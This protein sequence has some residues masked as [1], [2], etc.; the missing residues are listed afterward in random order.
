MSDFQT[1]LDVRLSPTDTASACRAAASAL[2]WAAEDEPIAAPSVT[3]IVVTQPRERL[4]FLG[5]PSVRR[6]RLE[7]DISSASATGAPHLTHISIRGS[8]FGVGPIV[9]GRITNETMRFVTALQVE[10]D[11]GAKQREQSSTSL[12][13]DLAQ[14]AALRDRGML[15]D[16]EYA[17]AKSHALGTADPMSPAETASEQT[18][19]VTGPEV[20]ETLETSG[21]RGTGNAMAGFS[22]EITGGVAAWE[23]QGARHTGRTASSPSGASHGKSP[24]PR[25]LALAFAAIVIVV[26]A[27]VTSYQNTHLSDA[28]YSWCMAH[29]AAVSLFKPGGLEPNPNYTSDCRRAYQADATAPDPAAGPSDGGQAT[30]AAGMTPQI[31]A[32]AGLV[33]GGSQM[34]T[35]SGS[36]F[37]THEPYVGD[38]EYIELSDLTNGWNAG[39]H[40]PGDPGQDLITL[41]VVSWTDTSIAFDI[42]GGPVPW[43][44][45]TGDQVRIR[46]W[47]PS[48]SQGPAVYFSAVGP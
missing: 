28:E 13:S 1:E 16:Q 11:R 14:L 18:A 26:W 23:S 5:E 33:A 24:S 19:R 9:A 35:I 39:W 8:M 45:Q 29:P 2:A 25:M 3:R 34:I 21:G 36:G 7:I 4:G 47:N 6:A 44:F 22:D 41:D 15:T 40:H 42:H 17:T 48:N 32:V 43:D 12:V 10:I 38:S 46:V 27:V 20:A 31:Q 30:A 37:G